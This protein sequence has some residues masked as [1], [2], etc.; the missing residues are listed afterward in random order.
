MRIILTSGGTAIDLPPDL[1][2]ADE[3]GWSAVAQ[4][5]KRSAFQTLIVSAMARQGGRPITLQGEG[6]SAWIDRATLKTIKS[7]SEVPGLRMQL[8]IRGEIFTVIF[9]HG[10]AEEM[11]ALAMQSVIDYADKQDG[12]YYCSLVLRFLEAS[13]L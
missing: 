9:D 1:V 10:D 7:W 2:W 13:E 8:D 3:L 6:N 4:S 11:R 12:D 5:T